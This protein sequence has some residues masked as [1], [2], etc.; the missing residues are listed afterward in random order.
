MRFVATHICQDG[1]RL[2]AAS[3]LHKKS[4]CYNLFNGMC[5]ILLRCCSFT[6]YHTHLMYECT[7]DLAVH[8]HVCTIVLVLVPIYN[9]T[10]DCALLG[11]E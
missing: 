6:I 1:N 7:Q 4:M 9:P 2:L 5:S 10:H 8:G 3:S 11:Y